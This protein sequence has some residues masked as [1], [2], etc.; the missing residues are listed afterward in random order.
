MEKL[1]SDQIQFLQNEV[2]KAGSRFDK[3]NLKNLSPDESEALRELF[4][5]IECVE[6]NAHEPISP[7][8][9][10]A[11]DIVDALE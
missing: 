1:N 11:A 9:R 4:F 2:K 3:L 6:A 10:M 8:G 5:D 7:R